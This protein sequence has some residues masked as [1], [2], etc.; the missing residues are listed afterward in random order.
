M[1]FLHAAAGYSV[2]STWIKAIQKGYNISWP[3]L[4]ANNVR[5]YLPKSSIT[6]RGHIDQLRKNTNSTKN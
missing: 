3:G 2:P 5:R 1:Q 6:A 4:T